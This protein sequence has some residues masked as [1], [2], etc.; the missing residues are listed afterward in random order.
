M[1]VESVAEWKW[2]TSEFVV[3]RERRTQSL[4]LWVMPSR[5]SV[6]WL[7]EEIW[8]TDTAARHSGRDRHTWTINSYQRRTGFYI[9]YL[10]IDF[11]LMATKTNQGA[12]GNET[13]ESLVCF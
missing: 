5:G 8:Q 1:I 2:N 11:N 6:T 7:S 13:S 3:T 4:E 12:P 10:F 9:I